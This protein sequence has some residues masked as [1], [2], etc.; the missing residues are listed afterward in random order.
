MTK[1]KT[2]TQLVRDL[3]SLRRRVARQEASTSKRRRAE[4]TQRALAAELEATNQRLQDLVNLDPLTE[5][6]NRRGLERAFATELRRTRRSGSHPIAVLLDCDDFERINRVFGHTVWDD[7]LVEIGR[8]ILSAVRLSDYVARVGGD[9]FLLILPETGY[10]EALRIAER[11]RLQVGVALPL[12]G[13]DP[14]RVTTSVGVC[15]VPDVALSV[16][17]IVELAQAALRK[18]KVAGKNRVV[19]EGEELA[20]GVHAGDLVDLLLV[21]GTYR[22]VQEPIVRLKDQRVAGYEFLTRTQIEGIELPG[23]FFRVALE[24]TSSRWPTCSA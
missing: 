1:A 2:K 7:V 24:T 22:A 11:V 3:E 17:E 12:G 14:V 20:A 4:Q 8:R 15:T 23:D 16:E 10:W 5:T 9:E 6:L 21:E 19:G 13:S 18:S